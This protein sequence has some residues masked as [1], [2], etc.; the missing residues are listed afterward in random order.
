MEHTEHVAASEGRHANVLLGPQKVACHKGPFKDPSI[1]STIRFRCLWKVKNDFS[2]VHIVVD[3]PQEM[4]VI[5]NSRRHS[6]VDQLTT[7]GKRTRSEKTFSRTCCY[8]AGRPG[9]G[10]QIFHKEGKLGS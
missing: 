6:A 1:P 3:P 7:I 2:F 5:V 4:T 9:V 8:G 10:I